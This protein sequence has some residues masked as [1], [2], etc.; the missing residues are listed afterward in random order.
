MTVDTLREYFPEIP[1][2]SWPKLEAW[3]VHLRDWNDK[4]NLISRKNIGMLEA[5]H[6]APC[7]AVT[8]FLKLMPGARIADVGTG[9]GL[10]GLPMAICYPDAQFTLI[11]SV[12][13]KLKVIEDIADK[14]GLDNVTTRHARAESLRTEFDFVTGRAVSDLPTFLGWVSGMLRVGRKHSIR[15]GVI[16]WRG[17]DLRQELSGVPF[18]PQS[19]YTL[20][21]YL[22]PDPE[23]YF[24]HKYILHF[25]A[26]NI[27]GFKPRPP[28]K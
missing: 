21:D 18:K 10:P 23:N 14:L 19:V 11:D 12:G 13:K 16:Y 6:L 22:P 9:G 17:G 20:T 28:A 1:E 5:H 15:N 24:D 2:E 7:L 27:R 26:G 8:R 4:V 25:D 3:A